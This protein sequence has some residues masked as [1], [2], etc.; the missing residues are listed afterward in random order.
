MNRT[1][2]TDD[3]GNRASVEYWG[4]EEEAKSALASLKDC[5]GC[6]DCSR[7]SRCSDCSYCFDCSRCSR[8]SGCS[9]CSRCSRCSGCSDSS[10]CSDC[11]RCLRCSYCS[12]CSD[13]SRCSRC[14]DL[15]NNAPQRVVEAPRIEN[16]HQAIYAA[17]SQPD[18]LNMGDWH[19]CET[20]HCRAGWAVHL[21][22]PAGYAL[23]KQTSS[24]FAAMQIYKASGY[25]ISPTRFYESNEA[26]LED[27]R[28]LAEA[29]AAGTL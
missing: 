14:S 9:D 1:W 21:A 13:C 20:T 23:E 28:K 8:C 11:S 6:S 12:R 19:S 3:N 10:Y 2:I 26:A 27:M 16:I 5:S 4:S 24:V 7:C 15:E 22:G 18:A 17:A 25:S 29:E